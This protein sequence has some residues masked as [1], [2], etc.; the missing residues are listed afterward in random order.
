MSCMG[1]VGKILKYPPKFQ[2]P[3]V[4]TLPLN[5]DGTCKYDRTVA[6]SLGYCLYDCRSRLE[7]TAVRVQCTAAVLEESK[8]LRWEKAYGDY[9]N[10]SEPL[11]TKSGS[12]PTASKKTGTSM[13][14]TARNQI[15][16]HELSRGFN[17]S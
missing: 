8:Y 10:C 16:Q 12:W 5:T 13:L 11:V 9:R 15:P 1:V 6:A 4:Y 3:G 7:G 2:L 17:S 14:K